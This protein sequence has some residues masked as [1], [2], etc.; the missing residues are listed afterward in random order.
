MDPARDKKPPSPPARPRHATFTHF[1]LF[2]VAIVTVLVLQ[3]V[4]NRLWDHSPSPSPSTISPLSRPVILNPAPPSNP[5]FN[6]TQR[7]TLEYGSVACW[8]RGGVWIAHLTPVE[9]SFLGLDR[10]HDTERSDDQAEEDAFC[11]RLRTMGASF[12]SLP[13]RWPD[14][15]NWCE[16]LDFCVQPDHKVQLSLGFT[17]SGGVWV[18]DTSV[19]RDER[20]PQSLG[21]NNALTMEERCIVLKD[22]GAKFCESMA[23]CPETAALLEDIDVDS[24][25]MREK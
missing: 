14:H 15:V 20:Y 4:T 5:P 25:D 13:P 18:L 7:Y 1:L 17:D 10:F 21:L 16:D 24:I 12:W 2:L 11:A 8:Q 19:G 23:A 6:P 3:S 22:L 9:L